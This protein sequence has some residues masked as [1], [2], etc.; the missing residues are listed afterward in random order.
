MQDQTTSFT[1]CAIAALCIG[2]GSAP[3]RAA[4]AEPQKAEEPIASDRPDFVE[5]SSV[6][7]KGRVQVE[8][9]VAYQ[10][11]RQ[12][13]GVRER[14][15][16]T[17][18]L[19]RFG[20]SDSVEVRLETEG[21]QHQWRRGGADSNEDLNGMADS[22]FSV[23]WHVRDGGPEG[24]GV[25]AL[26]LLLDAAVPS[27]AVRARE[28]G[29]AGVRP[30]LRGVAEWE[31]DDELSL[32]VMPGLVR[33]RNDKGQRYTGALFAVSLEK[34]WSPRWHGFI[35][36]AA[37]RIARGRDGG[38]QLSFDFGGAYLVNKD[39]QVD[40][41]VFRGL[42]RNTPDWSIGLGLSFRL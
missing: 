31:L 41:G 21:W 28:P 37:P 36:L 26:G 2:L 16:S 6:V 18:T 14:A 32:G 12:D 9:S 1:L 30:T 42:N 35:E 7:G 40:A 15:T 38:S 24:S 20:V 19:L 34:A 5:S 33:D 4:G 11:Q 25:P 27:G 17:P 39:V 8:T 22:A 3:A 29:S 23:K 10:R 13:G